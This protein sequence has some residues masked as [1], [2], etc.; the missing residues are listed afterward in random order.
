MKRSYKCSHCGE[1]NPDNFT[2][3]I[4]TMCRRCR[5]KKSKDSSSSEFKEAVNKQNLLNQYWKVR[6]A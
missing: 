4:N 1:E 2:R 3:R 5:A 6:V